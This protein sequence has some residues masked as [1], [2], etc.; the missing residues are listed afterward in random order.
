VAGRSLGGVQNVATAPR[1][2]ADVLV[3]RVLRIPDG[4]AAPEGAAQRAFS[5][6]ILVSATRCLLT[7]VVLPFL[8]PALGLAAGV[9]PAIG[10]PV[11]VVAIVANVLTIRR[12]WAA[13]H[14]RRWAYT[15][16]SLSVIVLL[17]I[18]LVEDVAS[19]IG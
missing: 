15:A 10:I 11:G 14:R 4:P 3:R 19:L 6:S 13:D 8:A 2:A 9:G 18:L 17:A 5:T 1:P 16:I 7:Y 12:F